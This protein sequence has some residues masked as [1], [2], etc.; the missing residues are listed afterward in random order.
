[1]CS[2]RTGNVPHLACFLYC[3]EE[4]ESYEWSARKYCLTSLLNMKG[5]ALEVHSRKQIVFKIDKYFSGFHQRLWSRF[6]IFYQGFIKDDKIVV[7]ARIKVIKVRGVI[8]MLKFDFSSP[9]SFV[10]DNVVLVVEGKKVHVGKQYLAMHSPIFQSMFY[11]EFVEKGK[12]E[13]ELKDVSHEEF[14]E[15]LY[16]I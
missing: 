5:E 10:A 9:P 13:I 14:I 15:L 7:E 16:V 8:S 4:N 1:E 2:E 11:G 6:R 3:N 12:E